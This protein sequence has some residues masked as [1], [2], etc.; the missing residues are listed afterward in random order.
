MA[1]N[2]QTCARKSRRV[3]RGLREAGDKTANIQ[4]PEKQ[5]RDEVRAEHARTGKWPFQYSTEEIKEKF[6]ADRSNLTRE[7][8][9][10]EWQDFIK[11]W[12]KRLN[13]RLEIYHAEM[14]S[15][16]PA[17]E[18]LRDFNL[19]DE[20]I[21]LLRNVAKEQNNVLHARSINFAAD[22]LANISEKGY[23]PPR[24][25]VRKRQQV[26]NYVM[27][28]WRLKGKYM[29]VEEFKFDIN[30]MWGISEGTILKILYPNSKT[31]RRY[32]NLYKNIE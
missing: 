22:L 8:I 23:R 32:K 4:K 28:Q 5:F 7:Q 24:A 3:S 27:F 14:M 18:E 6:V 15:M 12:A 13:Q 31:P 30:Q 20:L 21:V 10:T 11:E 16:K 19:F 9:E 17:L 26:R 2:T 25:S 1:T 29:T